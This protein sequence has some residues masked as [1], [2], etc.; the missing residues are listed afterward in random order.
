MQYAAA[1]QAR[2]NAM[3][4]EKLMLRN[5]GRRR[6]PEMQWEQ[7][8]ITRF[9][10]AHFYTQPSGLCLEFFFLLACLDQKILKK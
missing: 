7:N 4:E 9:R 6:R 8:Y 10:D 2:E 5:R 1:M 3:R